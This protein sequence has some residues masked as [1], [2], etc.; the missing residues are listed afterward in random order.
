M[1]GALITVSWTTFTDSNS[2]GGSPITGYLLSWNNTGTSA[3]LAT[4]TGASTLSYSMTNVSSTPIPYNKYLAFTIR[5]VNANGNGISSAAYVIQ[6]P[7]TPSVM[8]A[9]TVTISCQ[10]ITLSWVALVNATTAGRTAANNY[11][12]YWKT[13][14]GGTWYSLTTPNS[15]YVSL[16]FTQLITSSYTGYS[17]TLGSLYNYYIQQCNEAGCGT[18]SPT[19]V[20]KTSNVPS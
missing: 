3:T 8:A 14:A 10:T 11:N 16:S 2:T 5:A 15:G 18:A 20:V 17:W 19:L 13:S 6:T 1:T 7:T 12:L 9:P 4:I